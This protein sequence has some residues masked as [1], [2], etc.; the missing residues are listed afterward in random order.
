M[1]KKGVDYKKLFYIFLTISIV[2]LVA[3][4]Y[5]AIKGNVE[6]QIGLAPQPPSYAVSFCEDYLYPQISEMGYCCINN[7]LNSIGGTSWCCEQEQNLINYWNL[8]CAEALR[9]YA[10]ESN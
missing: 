10:Q 4:L 6:S 9:E 5:L 1:P 7:P 8:Q 2:L 3:L